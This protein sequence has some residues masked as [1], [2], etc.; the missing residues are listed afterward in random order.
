MMT[1]NKKNPTTKSAARLRGNE[2]YSSS[3]K[4]ESWA[5]DDRGEGMQADVR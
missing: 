3:I 1:L 4:C 5:R 2:L